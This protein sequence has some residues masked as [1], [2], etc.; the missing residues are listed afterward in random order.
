M[1]VS[2]NM[3]IRTS[4]ATL[5]SCTENID[6]TPSGAL[7]H[8]IM[9]SIAEFYSRNLAAEVIKGSVQKARSGGT[10]GKAPTG[11]LNVRKWENG[12][13]IRTV[14]I[15]PL[16][17][18]IMRWVF[19][20]YATGEWSLRRLLEAATAKGL[21]STG[22]PRTPSKPLS[23]ANFNRL[24]KTTYF[25]GLVTYQGVEY[26]GSH[27]PLISKELFD[28]VQAVLQAHALSGEKQRKHNHFLKGTIFCKQCGSRLGV[29]N[30]KNRHGTVYPYFYC[31]G[32]QERRTNCRQ[33]TVLIAE[34]EE[35]VALLWKE[36]QL[37]AEERD[38][39]ARF[40]RSELTE[41]DRG[42]QDERDR[43]KRRIDQLQ[44]E[45]QKLL[46]A[47]YADALPLDLLRTEQQRITSE[48]EGAERLLA[49]AEADIA[50]VTKAVER[51]LD[52]MVDGHQVYENSSDKV[53][54]GM[55]QSVFSRILV[56]DDG[57]IEGQVT[58]EY[59]LLLHEDVVRAATQ[60]RPSGIG[61]ATGTV[62]RRHLTRRHCGA[63]QRS[64][65]HDVLPCASKTPEASRNPTCKN[66]GGPSLAGVQETTGWWARGDLNPHVLANTGT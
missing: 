44:W 35:R 34:V 49:Q 11:Y 33:R 10:V 56:G 46:Q 9:S 40:I 55:N 38:L 8:G 60:A 45:R 51:A 48:I 18:P 5:V 17:G 57:G 23:L 14:E 24:L 6:E 4:G 1:D 25:F 54:R 39:L 16:R 2:I 52:L 41:L 20:E 21:S 42:N 53:R 62:Q 65:D 19:E 58:E 15:D 37:T 47:H 27:E 36:E 32:K 13:E 50:T 61:A 29:M 3:A 26:P 12:R 22:G 66:R 30:A 31:S 63:S 7:M 28:R 64:G 59:E 43:Q